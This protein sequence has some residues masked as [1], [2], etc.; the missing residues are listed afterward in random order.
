MFIEGIIS[1]FDG[2]YILVM[3]YSLFICRYLFFPSYNLKP[4]N[5]DCPLIFMVM[6]LF[7]MS[8]ILIDY[9]F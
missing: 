6:F 8:F 7:L 1:Y 3:L 9:V 2:N 5:P 4:R